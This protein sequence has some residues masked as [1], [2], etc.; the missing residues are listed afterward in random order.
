V[1]SVDEVVILVSGATDGLGKPTA[2]DLDATRATV[3]LHSA[4]PD[5]ATPRCARSAKIPSTT[6]SARRSG[7]GCPRANAPRWYFV[8][9]LEMRAVKEKYVLEATKIGLPPE[10]KVFMQD[11]KEDFERA[12]VGLVESREQ[13]G[14]TRQPVSSR[15]SLILE[16]QRGFLFGDGEGDD[17][18]MPVAREALVLIQEDTAYD[19]RG[20]M[21]L[22][23]VHASAYEQDR[24]SAVR[25]L[26]LRTGD[27]EDVGV[28]RDRS[29][30]LRAALGQ[31]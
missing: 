25:P 12:R 2:R 9:V 29:G 15:V 19:Y 13:H 5:A 4:I 23:L 18:L 22:S 10:T 26:E 20:R 6:G 3:L 11:T 8:R 31:P 14:R 16:G 27:P 30:K 21:R 24:R 28:A 17:E 1:R 7:G